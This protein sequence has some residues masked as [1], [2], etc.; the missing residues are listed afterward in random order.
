MSLLRSQMEIVTESSLKLP[1]PGESR[2]KDVTQR[3]QLPTGNSDF[4][5]SVSLKVPFI[6]SFEC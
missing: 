2:V 6:S 4:Y 3:A 5:F 1:A